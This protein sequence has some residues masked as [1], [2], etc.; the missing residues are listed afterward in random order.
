MWKEQSTKSFLKKIAQTFAIEMNEVVNLIFGE[1]IYDFE[2][3]N[4]LIRL[5]VVS[6]YNINDQVSFENGKQMSFP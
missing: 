6:G 4:I 5:L 1:I 2:S 3:Q